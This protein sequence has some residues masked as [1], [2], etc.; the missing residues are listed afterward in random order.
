MT[1]MIQPP[2]SNTS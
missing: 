2:R 1:A